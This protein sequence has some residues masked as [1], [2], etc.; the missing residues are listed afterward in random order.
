VQIPKFDAKPNPNPDPNSYLNS[1]PIGQ[2]NC[3]RG[4]GKSYGC[5]HGRG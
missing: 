1:N 5:G 2:V 3:P 4:T